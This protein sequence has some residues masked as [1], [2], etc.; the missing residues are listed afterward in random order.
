MPPRVQVSRDLL[1]LLDGEVN[2]MSVKDESIIDRRLTT[3]EEIYIAANA[4]ADDDDPPLSVPHFGC[5]GETVSP[6]GDQTP[7][8]EGRSRKGHCPQSIGRAIG[9]AY[10]HLQA[11]A[12]SP[13]CSC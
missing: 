12:T 2:I 11:C 6:R 8:T 7:C 9:R 1:F 3:T 10:P 5:F 13:P 4:K